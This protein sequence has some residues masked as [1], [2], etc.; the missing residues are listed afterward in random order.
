[1]FPCKQNYISLQCSF[2]EQNRHMRSS[3]LHR[4]HVS[5]EGRRPVPASRFQ[6]PSIAVQRRLAASRLPLPF[7]PV[8]TAVHVQHLP[9][10]LPSFRQVNDSAGK[11]LNRG[12]CAHGRKRFQE[13]L[14]IV[15]VKRGVDGSGGA[16]AL[17]RICS[18]AY[19]EAKLLNAASRPPF[20]IIGKEAGRPAIRILNQ[21]CG[22]AHDAA[23]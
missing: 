15:G 23:A 11:V 4:F 6:A 10:D 18:F 21:R 16:M 14:R 5:A 20:V 1:M 2:G 13:V 7:A 22:D 12:D 17:N 19:S 9:C 3:G 8:R